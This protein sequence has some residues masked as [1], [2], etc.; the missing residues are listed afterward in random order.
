MYTIAASLASSVET[1]TRCRK[2]LYPRQ[3]RAFS[4]FAVRR[5]WACKLG[6]QPSHLSLGLQHAD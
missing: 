1:K 2:S 3:T 5:R 6:F 4:D